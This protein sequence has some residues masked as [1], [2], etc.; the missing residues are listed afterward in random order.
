M[1]VQLCAVTK[2]CGQVRALVTLSSRPCCRGGVVVYTGCVYLDI[3]TWTCRKVTITIRL[4]YLAYTIEP[5]PAI[6]Y[7]AP[8]YQTR[9]NYTT[10]TRQWPPP[11]ECGMRATKITSPELPT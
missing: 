4:L 7:N 5:N 10:K 8:P 1:G 2:S 3:V 11:H 6:V 9:N